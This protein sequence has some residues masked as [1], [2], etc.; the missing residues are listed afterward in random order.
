MRGCCGPFSGLAW[1]HAEFPKSSFK[2][3][4]RKIWRPLSQPQENMMWLKN[5][6]THSGLYEARGMWRAT[7]LAIVSQSGGNQCNSVPPSLS[8]TSQEECCTKNKNNPS[9]PHSKSYIAYW[10]SFRPIWSSRNRRWLF[11]GPRES[12]SIDCICSKRKI[13]T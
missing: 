12:V 10:F 13:C 11:F 7:G 4:N 9:P 5:L 3:A 2:A 6:T 1:S 8:E